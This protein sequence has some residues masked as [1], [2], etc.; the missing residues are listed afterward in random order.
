MCLVTG[1]SSGLGA[2]FARLL[3][4][5]GYNVLLVARRRER[6]EALADE[7]H[8]HGVT[9]EVYCCDLSD[10]AARA[11]LIGHLQ[12][13]DRAVDMLINNAGFGTAGRYLDVSPTRER[14]MI[15]VNIDAPV[16]LCRAVIGGMTERRSGAILNVSSI[17]AFAP[18]PGMSLY[19]GTKAMLLTF[20]ASIHAE[21]AGHGVTV[22]VLTP[23]GIR[24]EFAEVA[25]APGLAARL[26]DAIWMSPDAVAA[27]GIAGL[28]RGRW[29]IVPGPLNRAVGL[30]LRHI[31]R[32]ILLAAAGRIATTRGDRTPT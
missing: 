7:L 18:L 31:P 22:T 2:A 13:H 25:G 11:G 17:A 3:A 10:R 1:A 19:T 29:L 8:A 23:G 6:L 15:G 16:E 26:P 28:E 24:T 27:H 20:S 5:R 14:E 32:T 30:I 21:L 4:G 9:A 12:N